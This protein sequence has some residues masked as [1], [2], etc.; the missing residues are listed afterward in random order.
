MKVPRN[1]GRPARV[2]GVA[3]LH[4]CCRPSVKQAA[5]RHPRFLVDERSELLVTE[6]VGVVWTHLQNELSP[7]QFLKSF[8]DLIVAASAHLPDSV[9]IERAAQR[10]CGGEDLTSGFT[11]GGEALLQKVTNT[12]RKRPPLLLW[13]SLRE[14]GDILG[15]EERNAFGLGE[16]SI[17]KIRRR[18]CIKRV[19]TDH[20]G[21]FRTPQPRQR[22]LRRYLV[23][24]GIDDQPSNP[25]VAC[26]FLGAPRQQQDDA[27]RLEPSY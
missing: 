10:S 7:D 1:D 24:P 25:I 21:D 14:C 6:I 19:G 5:A 23:G 4:R 11:D 12:S 27:L 26:D 3:P 13:R 20:L 8:D 16:E 15:N 2:S 22:D 17:L 18:G 9:E